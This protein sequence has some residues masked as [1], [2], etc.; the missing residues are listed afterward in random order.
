MTYEDYKKELE[1]YAE[2]LA[3]TSFANKSF[4]PLEQRG[5]TV[6][7]IKKFNVVFFFVKKLTGE[8]EEDFRVELTVRYTLTLQESENS[9]TEDA[10]FT[11]LSGFFENAI[12]E[13]VYQAEFGDYQHFSFDFGKPNAIQ[14]FDAEFVL[15]EKLGIEDDEEE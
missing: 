15:E 1:F 11:R 12:V 10:T 2:K 5:L 3:Y 4:P 9:S 6:E 13:Q 7:S 8:D 14:L